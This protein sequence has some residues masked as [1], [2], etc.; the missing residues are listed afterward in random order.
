MTDS[1]AGALLDSPL[2]APTTATPTRIARSEFFVALAL[3]ALA[4]QKQR[5]LQRHS[6]VDACANIGVAAVSIQALLNRRSNPPVPKLD[7]ASLSQGSKIGSTAA[8]GQSGF[9]TSPVHNR[10]YKLSLGSSGDPWSSSPTAGPS[11]PSTFTNGYK[12]SPA[13]YSIPEEAASSS[14]FK[15]S[16]TSPSRNGTSSSGAYTGG[17]SSFP[18]FGENDQDQYSGH[19]FG[20]SS[21]GGNGGDLQ[22]LESFSSAADFSR[23]LTRVDV[24]QQA[25][26]AGSF[27]D[28][29][30]VYLVINS[31]SRPT[32]HARTGSTAGKASANGGVVRRYSD[33]V[34]LNE[35]LERKYPARMRPT[36]PPK[37]VGSKCSFVLAYRIVANVA[38]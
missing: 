12:A 24:L 37:R 10:A 35:V 23:S 25:E 19:G 29:H 5:A 36:L 15:P 16:Y 11:A 9:S 33:W 34:W 8:S 21:D 7:L 2:R 26:I 31:A 28:R 13:P 38:E 20:G 1:Y 3:A 17:Y 4:Q 14:G 32:G 30:T 18:S 6:D 22:G 27:W